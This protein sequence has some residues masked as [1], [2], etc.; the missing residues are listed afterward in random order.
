MDIISFRVRKYRNIQDSGEVELLDRLTCIVG[1]NQ[2]GKTALLRALHKFNPRDAD[3][4]VLSREW[5]RGH[6]LERDLNEI[7][8]EVKFKLAVDEQRALAE[9][10]SKEMK[11]GEV[12]ITK[13]YDGKFEIH[14]PEDPDLF[15]NAL[16]PNSI[17]EICREFPR[18]LEPVGPEFGYVAAGCI[19]EATRLAKEGRFGELKNLAS[20]QIQGLQSNRSEQN[21][22]RQ[23]EDAFVQAYSRKLEQVQTQLEQASTMQQRAHDYL[24]KRIPTFIYMEEYRA[25]RGSAG[26][27][28]LKQQR[29]NPRY[30]LTQEEETILMILKLSGLDLDKLIE[31]GASG[32]QNIIHERQLD[33]QDAARTLTRQVAGRWGQN[34]YRIE[35][36]AD[37]QTFFTEIEETD[38]DVGMIPLEEQSKGFQWFFSFDLHFM[39]DSEGT[40]EGFVLLLDEPGLHLHPG[41]QDDLLARLDAYAE[42][43]TLIY[44]TH[45]PFMVDLREPQRV[46]VIGQ[47]ENGAVVSDDLGASQ[48]EEKLTLQ[49]ALGM[50]ARQSNLVCERN[51]VVEG[52]EDY[53]IIT[54][55]SNVFERS[56]KP[57]LPEDV[58]VT[59]CGGASEV[60]HEATFMVGQGLQVVA[61]F[62]SDGE[63]EAQRARLRDK[64]LTRYKGARSESLLIGEILSGD[65]ALTIEDLFPEDYYLEKLLASHEQKLKAKGID[66]GQMKLEG[67]GPIVPRVGRACD[68]LDVQF[69]KGSVGKLIKR[70]LVLWNSPIALPRGTQ[71]KAEKL[72]SAIRTAFER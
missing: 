16:H 6:R 68:A 71:E 5:P 13:D 44:T 26:L 72:L 34:N 50:K 69:S 8:C 14:F 62:D 66:K 35:F 43:N 23:N 10:T 24:V 52:P 28:E 53:W 32:D 58:M 9:L 51:L 59:A 67:E 48:P 45:L 37:G 4:Y 17:D 65:H 54:A 29:D 12:L 3:P 42:K 57:G 33:L 30:R 25:F 39:H 49:A 20:E 47:T 64:W 55:L 63:G 56:G 15:P 38:K 7:V 27:E 19:N 1:K 36:R 46:K 18:W 40:F 41:G 2:S 21:P 11:A 61:L 22:E 60:V 70:D 31:Q